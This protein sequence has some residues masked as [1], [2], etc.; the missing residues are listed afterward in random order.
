MRTIRRVDFTVV[1]LQ[2]VIQLFCIALVRVCEFAMAVPDKDPMTKH[3]AAYLINC[4]ILFSPRGPHSRV[5]FELSTY[6]YAD[7][8]IFRLTECK[9]ILTRVKDINS[10]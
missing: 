9:N 5:L 10:R 1:T 6:V 3:V 4:F 2:A 8:I 7:S